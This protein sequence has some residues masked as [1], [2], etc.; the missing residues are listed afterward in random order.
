MCLHYLGKFE[1]SEWA[2]D[3]MIKCTFEWLTEQRQTWLAVIVSRKSHTCH[4]SHHHDHLYYS[5]CSKCPPPARTQAR[6]R[7]CH[8]PTAH[9]ITVWL[10][11]AHSLLMRR[12]FRRRRDLGTIDSLLINVKQITDFQRV[13]GLAM[14]L[15]PSMH[16]T[17]Y[18]F[19][20]VNGQTTTSAFHKVV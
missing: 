11:V 2:V 10:R 1:V 8:S 4:I 7:W 15:W 5:V 14:I 17:Q 20:V 18:E 12:S 3:T 13:C 19:I 9:S 16:Y 6:W